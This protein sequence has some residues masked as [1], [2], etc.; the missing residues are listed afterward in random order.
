MRGTVVVD[1]EKD[2]QAWLNEQPTFAQSL[3]EADG[4][5]EKSSNRVFSEASSPNR[6]I[7][8]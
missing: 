3:A 5:S 4:D 2:F 1:S 8:R 6:G 7:A